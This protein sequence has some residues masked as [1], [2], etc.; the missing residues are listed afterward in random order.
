MIIY[1]A[2]DIKD[3]RCVRLM[4]GKEDQVTIYDDDPVAV[5]L[6]WQKEGA[7]FVHVVDLDGAF[8]GKPDHRSHQRAD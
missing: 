6:K 3:G 5:A 8:Q 7:E 4:Q 1:P 2:I